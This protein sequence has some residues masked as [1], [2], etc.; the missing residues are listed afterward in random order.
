MKTILVTAYAINPYKGSEDG[1]GWNYVRQVARFNKVIAITRENNLTD[2]QRY[3]E[4]H[5]LDVSNIEFKGYDLPYWARWWKRGGNGAMLYFY[6]WQM[7]IVGFI[8]KLN[9]SFDI[10]HNLNFHTD[11]VPTFLWMLGKPVVWGPVGHHPKVPKGYYNTSNA[12]L[13]D[14]SKNHVI[15]GLKLVLWNLDPFM[16]LA[17]KNVSKVICINLEVERVLKLPAHKVIRFF[18]VGVDEIHTQFIEKTKFRVLSVGRIVPLKGFDITVKSFKIFLDRLSVEQKEDVELVLV[19]KGKSVYQIKEYIEA[20]DLGRYIKLI[21]WVE[22]KELKRYYGASSLFFFPS[23]EGAGMVVPEAFSY[24]LPVL[25]FDNCGPGEF[26]TQN[27]G[28]KLP[29]SDYNSSLSGFA[30]ELMKLF[31]NREELG[32]LSIGAKERVEESF[33]WDTKGDVL[34]ETYE[35][36]NT[37]EDEL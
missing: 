23:H 25:C 30:D 14:R 10:V 26:V 36:F 20:N 27:C 1:T 8:K 5:Q 33:L 34:K 29:Y 15:Y 32:R 37:K 7:F 35:L 9:Q 17:K 3:V 28:V 24:G 19:G 13:I 31:N 2:I 11:S 16:A 22:Q 21:N 4:E 12:T 18:S 6:L